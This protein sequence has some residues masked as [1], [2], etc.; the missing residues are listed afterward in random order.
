[1][2]ASVNKRISAAENLIIGYDQGLIFMVTSTDPN[3][4]MDYG[5]LKILGTLRLVCLQETFMVKRQ[6]LYHFDIF[7]VLE[8]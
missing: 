1:M 2:G 7:N 4:S 6:Q 8:S 3:L 5:I